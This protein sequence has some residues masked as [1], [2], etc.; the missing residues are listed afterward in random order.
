MNRLGRVPVES[1][2]ESSVEVS[3]TVVS[4]TLAALKSVTVESENAEE[5]VLV[6]S[7]VVPELSDNAEP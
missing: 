5:S 1:W 7:A 4:V 2:F 3:E 6:E